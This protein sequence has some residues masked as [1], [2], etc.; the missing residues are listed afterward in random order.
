MVSPFV[1][2]T[3]T[4]WLCSVVKLL[5]RQERDLQRLKPAGIIDLHKQYSLQFL[6][7]PPQAALQASGTEFKEMLQGFARTA[8]TKHVA[9]QPNLCLTY[10]SA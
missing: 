10:E 1:S 8:S 3:S 7:P 2:F 9:C 5:D 6:Q 4:W